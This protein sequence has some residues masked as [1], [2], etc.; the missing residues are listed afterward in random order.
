M[1]ATAGVF[2]G[3][4]GAQEPLRRP[5]QHVALAFLRGLAI[6]VIIDLE[7]PRGGLVRIEASEDFLPDVRERIRATMP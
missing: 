2:I 4:Q 7:Y 1:A 6:F 3:I 5:L